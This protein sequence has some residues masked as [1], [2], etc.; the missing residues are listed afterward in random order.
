MAIGSVI[1]V[2]YLR[3]F[4]ERIAAIMTNANLAGIHPSKNNKSVFEYY[5]FILRTKKKFFIWFCLVLY[6]YL[7]LFS[8]HFY[9]V[10]FDFI[11]F[12]FL[13]GFV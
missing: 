2:K 10:L 4:N 12:S 3:V 8:F 9:L 5:S 13:F 6:F 7:A 11:Q 1:I